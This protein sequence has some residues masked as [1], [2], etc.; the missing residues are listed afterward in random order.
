MFNQSA[1]ATAPYAFFIAVQAVQWWR[2]VGR[3]L[4]RL[5]LEVGA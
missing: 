1:R 3:Y 2:D 4:L 5:D